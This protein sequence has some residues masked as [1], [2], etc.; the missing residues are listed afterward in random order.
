MI[1]FTTCANVA[2]SFLK[3]L[4]GY[5][6]GIRFIA[7]LTMLCTIGVG[8]MWGAEATVY[9]SNVEL[10]TTSG[11]KATTSKAKIS[12]VDYNAMKLGS[13]G[14][15][16]NFYVTI[17]AN[18]TTLTLH[19]AAWNGKNSNTLTLSTETAGVTISPSAAQ[20]LTANSGVSGSSTTYTI[21][22]N[23][24]KEFFT[25]TITGATSEAR[26]KLACSERCLIWGVNAETTGGGENPGEGGGED[27]ET[28]GTGGTVTYTVSSATAVTTSGIVP[29]GSSASLSG[30]GSL[31]SGFIQCTNE[32]NHTLT[33]E[34]YAGYK[35][36]SISI[37]VKS[38]SSKGTGSF[39]VVAGSTTIASITESAFNTANWNGSWNNSGVDKVLTMTN[40]SY[41]I[42]S[43]E[44]VKLTINCKSGSSDYNSLYIKSYTIVYESTST[45]GETPEPETPATELTND[46]FA[47]SA[48]TAEATMGA[49]NTFPTLT[50][51]LSVPVTY[52]SSTPA[53]ATIA[54]DGTIT[55]VAPGTTTISAKFAGGEVGG[56]TYA[57]K[58]VTY[59]LTVL[60]APAT[61][62]STVYVKVTST[63][64]ITDGEYLIVYEDAEGNPKAPV[65]FDGSLA[66]VKL[67]VA[68]NN[69]EV[70][71]ASNTI[72]GNTDIDAATF[73]INTTAGTIQT[74]DGYYIGQTSNANGLAT[75]TTT[76]YTNTI[77]IENDGSATIIS[78]GG[79][80]LRY[81]SDAN[82]WRFRY[83][84][85]GSYTAQKAI[86]LYKKASSHTLTYGTC[87]NGSVSADVAN[88]AT[89]LSGTT[90]TL[91]NTPATNY[92]LSAYDVYKTGDKTT[93]VTV[94]DGQFVMP[95]YD[96]T[97]SAT[98]VPVK[99]LTS[100]EITTPATQ[101]TFWQGETFNSTGLVVT[102]HFTGAADEVVTPTITGSTATAGTQT[103]T[104]SYTEGTVTKTT[105]YNITVKAT[106]NTEATAYD[107]AT[108]REIIDKVSTANDIYV[109]GIVSEIVT[110]Y[111]ATY[112]NISYN[113]SADGL[114]SSAQL[115]AYRGK[116]FDGDNFTS[117]EDVK[118]GDEVIVFGNLL[119]YNETYELAADNK[120]ISLKREK[121]AAGLAYATTEYTANVGEAFETPV[122]TNPNGLT[123]TY[124]TSDASKATVNAT[125]GAVTIVAEGT[126][127]I[128]ATFEGNASYYAGTASYTITISDPSKLIAE[129]PFTFDGG[130]A[131]IEN[132]RGMSQNGLGSDY[133]SAPL[134]KFD[135]TGDYVIIHFDSEPGM[136]SYDI[137]GNSYSGGTFTVQESADGSEYTNIVGYTELGSKETKT[138]T[139]A[140]TSRYVKFIYTEKV[141]GNVALGNITISKPDNRAEADLAWDPETVTLTVGAAFT[142]P[143]LSNPN[144]VSGIT[145]ESSNTDVATV[146]DAGVITL[147]ESVTGTA[148]ITATFAGNEDY[149]PAEVSCT[150]TVNALTT[151]TVTLNPNYPAGKTGTF[152]DKEENTVNGNLEISL[153]A[154]TESQEIKNL[155]S[156]IS[157]EGYIFEGWYEAADGDVHRVNTG[158]ISKDITFYAHWRVPYTVYFN[159]GT[160]TC[161]GSITETTANGIQLP[162]ATLEDCDDWTF[163]GWAEA[164]IASETKT[165]PASFL[166]GGSTY[167]PTDDITLYAIYKRVEGEGGGEGTA[168]TLTF[169]NTSKRTT[170]TTEQQVWTENGITLT[171][172][173]ASSTSNVADY[174]NP[175]RFYA[176]SE[177]IISAPANINKIVANCSKGASDLVSSVGAEASN[178]NNAVTIVP[179]SSNTTYTI[180]QLSAQVQM[181]SITV[182]YGGGLSTSYYY[183]NPVCQT[184]ENILTIAKGTETN[185]TFTLNISGDIETC[186][187]EV[188][189]VVKPTSANHYHIGSVTAT[190]PTTGG[191]PTVTDNDNGTYTIT[192]AANSTGT[193]TINVTFAED[194]KA[195]IKLYELGVLTTI[196]TEYVGDKYTL[197][198]T[199]SQLCG[200]KT[201]VGWST[202][203]FAETDTRPT[204]NYYG[205]STQITLAETQTFYAVFAQSN[206]GGGGNG[207]YARVTE[208]LGDWS[209]DYLI[210]YND[211]TFANGSTGG[212]SGMGAKGNKQDLSSSIENNTI[213]ASIG[214]LYNVTLVTVDGGYVLQTKDGK[215]NYYT[216][217]AS[218][219]LSATESL[220]T[221]KNYPIVIDFI[222]SEDIELHITK[223]EERLNS[224]FS[225]NTLETG[226]FRFYKEGGQEPVY[227]YKKS[228]TAATYTG[229]TTSCAVI[230]GIE[231][232]NP[233][234]EFKQYDEFVFGGTVYAVDENDNRIDVTSSATFSGYDMKKAGKDTVTVTYNSH[235]TTYEITI[236][237]VNAYALTWNV[238]G[239]TNTGLAPAYVVPGNAIG[240]LPTPKEI[241]AG[242]E[243]KTFVGWTESN[244]VNSD[245]T[246]ITFIKST[247]VPTQ[248]T[249]YYA[250]FATSSVDAGNGDYV[251]LTET[252][253]DLSGEYLIVYEGDT[254][255]S[256][257]GAKAFNGKLETLD[258]KDNTISVSISSN[259]ITSTDATN[260]AK[261]TIAKDGEGD[262]TIKSTSGKYI[263]KTA[264][265]NDLEESESTP[266]KNTITF[267]DGNVNIIASGG[268][269]L[270][271]NKNSGAERFRYYQS[272]TY[273]QQ[274]PIALYKKSGSSASYTDYTTGCHDVTITYY[275]FTG[276]YTTNCGGNDL[277]VI[278][279]RVNSAHTI[280]NCTE[281]TD[282]TTLGRTFLNMWKD[283][284]GKVH[285]PGETFIV[286]D[287]ITLY[288][289]WKL[290]TTGDIELPADKEDLATTD[291]VVTGGKTLTIPEGKT[292]TINSLTL[293][294]GLLGEN[295]ES[296]YAMPS[297]VIP[298]DATLV[299]KNT[300]INLDLVVN[301]DSWYPFAVPFAIDDNSN[302]DYLDPVLKAASTY[303]THFAIKT[304]DGANRAIVGTDQEN[305]WDKVK[306]TAGL[307]PGKGYIIS[308][309]TYPDKDTATIRIPMSV[310]NDWLANG[311]LTTVNE[312]TRNT[313]AVIA[314]TGEAAEEHQRHAG[315]NFVAN[316]YLANFAGT[317][318]SGSFITGEL[319]I[320]K[321][322]YSYSEDEVPYVTIPTYNFEHY[323]Q[324][325]LSEATLSPAYSF[326]VQVGTD[327][328]M[329]FDVAGRQQAPASIAARNAE[330]RPV[331][332]DVDITLSDN[333]SSDQTGIII[334]DRYNDTYE[335]GR[336]L[337]KLFGS[338]YNLSVYT[339]MADN[340]PLA[341]QA[342][343]IRS[344]MQVIPVGYRAPEQG[345]Y[346]FRLNEAT[347]SIDLL[348]EQYEQLVL[349]D[350]QTG[351]LTNLLI[352]DYTFYSERTQADNR[353]A[354]YAV[355]RQNA[356]TDLPNAIGQDKQAQKIIHNGHLY[357]LRDGNVYNG[358][359]Q[360]VK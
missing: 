76:E 243:G 113:I 114:T 196:A 105:T 130:K 279:Q 356:P 162:T 292:I 145:Y 15:S 284:N 95:E 273:D 60:K 169:D 112:G 244:T 278:T 178:S 111:N 20:T 339:L 149:K 338:A 140:A 115:Q 303:N 125:T 220:E 194:A 146:N 357:I 201:L 337:E 228:G 9:T 299:R 165:A 45:G 157:L 116:S 218:N 275:G 287:N 195:T 126:V 267:T 90:I 271:Y 100:I 66:P 226:F 349:V 281:I 172:N 42:Q 24:T 264:N 227:L 268:A 67:D 65:A 101:T 81:N 51:T 353:F 217:G 74:K 332:M 328:T 231:V 50:N 233:K 322:D 282:P 240:K 327:G 173:K 61:P 318:A 62:T 225:Y 289:Q 6:K 182:T 185:G 135:G 348:N 11:T 120:L 128:T 59:A 260:A 13:S 92:K 7:L 343:A 84:K 160:G 331:K 86:A 142:A 245:G 1:N 28:P 246:E 255:N 221:A 32:K 204:E 132:T 313:V 48:A 241:P 37:H 205:I 53:T 17:P 261:F 33:L 181:S 320:N 249:T 270:R 254:E 139:L 3:V 158:D 133:G 91:S 288:A 131:D 147:K 177:I 259:T 234:T 64:G 184:C 75:S 294:G 250:V 141:S 291:I 180:A 352:A 136:L 276:G 2:N 272:S 224:V 258:A 266:Y 193:S 265:D 325:K 347:S 212:T 242:C 232:A 237:K 330:E 129:L 38:N 106:A 300:T 52:E 277:N 22:P 171:N 215:Y 144:S 315:W 317:N 248:H 208:A 80:Y 336:D 351:E 213:P 102:A 63:A 293:K 192:Y 138:H 253:A 88:G 283:Q 316:P 56:T 314:Y 200:T 222:S 166:A 297:V 85:S 122:L 324:V 319:L 170:L 8:Q 257:A 216:S 137:K 229:Y 263:G 69:I 354:I 206:G 295:S 12:S 207:D 308:A 262:Y 290:E 83:Y 350:Y 43:G 148:I 34:G 73:T 344:N 14:N 151:Y 57:P 21:T 329:T 174:S 19:A 175:A 10:S 164:A 197:P 190:T 31:S 167:K 5:T 223:N 230:T 247:T 309:L 109:T 72:A 202:V 87:T 189:V 153:P 121:V 209:G 30:T 118:V 99:T 93:K 49:S 269:Y 355:P 47:W 312:V 346:T 78:S 94:T 358:N 36:K 134:L 199:S 187:T 311:E 70:S 68:S 235:S 107:V 123:V 333:H 335:I 79:A 210:A 156:S 58:T 214:D 321:G 310:S 168:A 360:I 285:Q 302:I 340:T 25:Y 82:N 238:S 183:S 256:Y 274:Q 26:I 71:I 251:K 345:E 77:S 161:T 23:N 143:T 323:Y 236:E 103:V 188:S 16:G 110:A 18:T 39:S 211:Q 163:L 203:A 154:N 296:G 98:F 191:A 186:E 150:I 159:A 326:F 46:Q 252:P 239:A 55:L 306:Q 305:N 29:D 152:I 301:N 117:A 54:A 97:I 219:G 179:T 119:K 334:S 307:Q 108:A 359:G 35:I 280:P 89:V 176:K 304:Y 104:V 40:D 41:E 127:T 198:S 298:D 44:D 96:V 4:Q 342:L 27:P 155:Y 124:S 341:F 286:T